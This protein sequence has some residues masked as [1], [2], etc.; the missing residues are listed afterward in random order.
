MRTSELS[1]RTKETTIAVKL[2]IDGS[3]VFK[4]ESGCGF[5]DH[6]LDLF[7]CHGRFDM[8]VSCKGDTE[9]DYHHSIEDIAIVLGQAFANALGDKAGIYRFANAIIPMDEALV[10]CAVDVCG[11][12]HLGYALNI[13]S[14][15]VG[16]FDTELV[17]EFMSAF[18]RSLGLAL[19]F[20]QLAGSNSHHIIEAAFKSLAR[21]LKKALSID[22]TLK[23]QVPSTKGV[24]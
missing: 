9:V 10:M 1:R 16:D 19:H 11:R 17:E 24:L 21:A 12:A 8:E 14:E 3:G 20:Q 2:N 6:M 13:P 7:A 15:K 5:L 23:G 18:T 22:P 4:N